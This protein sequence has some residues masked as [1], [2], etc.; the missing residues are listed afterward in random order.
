MGCH[1]AARV[2]QCLTGPR[3]ALCTLAGE[4]VEAHRLGGFEVT[5]APPSPQLLSFQLYCLLFLSLVLLPSSEMK[6]STPEADRSNRMCFR[7]L[8]QDFFLLIICFSNFRRLWRAPCNKTDDLDIPECPLHIIRHHTS[9]DKS[10]GEL[11]SR[12]NSTWCINA[13]LLI[14]LGGSG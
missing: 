11:V 10:A 5:R 3:D 14:H 7:F 9:R 6:S 13:K 4:V 12:D 1:R 2:R 8:A